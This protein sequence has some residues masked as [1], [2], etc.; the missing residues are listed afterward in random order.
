MPPFFFWLDMAT[1]TTDEIYQALADNLLG[2]KSV[3]TD[4]ETVVARDAK[5]FLDAAAAVGG[6]QAGG[7]SHRGLRFSQFQPPGGGG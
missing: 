4:K 3:T 7:K 2:P 5:D 1:P 6:I